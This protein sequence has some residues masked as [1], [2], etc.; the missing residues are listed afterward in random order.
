MSSNLGRQ[1]D[2]SGPTLFPPPATRHPPPE[3][4][5]YVRQP[6]AS[7]RSDYDSEI[8]LL[9]QVVGTPQQRNPRGITGFQSGIT[10]MSR[11]LEP[12]RRGSRSP[13]K[14]CLDILQCR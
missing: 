13:R 9:C 11:I 1:P 2:P 8:A 14:R 10:W 6:R 7:A 12:G 4:G 5:T 3:D